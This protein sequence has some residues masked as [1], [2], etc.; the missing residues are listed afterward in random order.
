MCHRKMINRKSCINCGITLSGKAR[1]SCEACRCLVTSAS[2]IVINHRDRA[3][4]LGLTKHF[5]LE[6]W[7]KLLVL[8][9]HRCLW[10]G[11]RY[12]ERHVVICAD[13]VV[14]LS[15]GGTNTIENL[16]PLCLK[17]NSK[18]RSA[19]TDYRQDMPVTAGDLFVTTHDG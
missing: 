10:C 7:L 8:Y 6:Q 2:N 19:S 16:Q 9:D 3:R 11:I 13:H 4:K 14:S 18:K 17:C 5:T 15:Q 1:I 12:D